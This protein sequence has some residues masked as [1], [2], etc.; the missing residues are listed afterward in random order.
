MIGKQTIIVEERLG[1]TFSYLPMI[2]GNNGQSYNPVFKAGDQKEL[3]AFFAQSQGKTNYPLIWLDMPIIERHKNRSRVDVKNLIMILAVETN[4]QMLY[5]ERI[6][7]TFKPILFKLLDDILDNF[8]ISN[9]VRYS[10]DFEI[11][12][13]GNYSDEVEIE[14]GKFVDIWDAIKLTIDVSINNECLRE[15]KT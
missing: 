12:K 10:G 6:D 13:F 14:K 9:I 2:I 8:T 3:N 15:I 4:S 11:S 5:S 1:E 7:K